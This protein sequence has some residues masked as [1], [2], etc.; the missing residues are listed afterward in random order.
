MLLS[1]IWFIKRYRHVKFVWS[2]D[3][4][5]QSCNFNGGKSGYME[6]NDAEKPVLNPICDLLKSELSW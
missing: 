1:G 2:V 4:L 6:N 5:Q 3:E